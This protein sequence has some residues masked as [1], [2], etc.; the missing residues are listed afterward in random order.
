MHGPFGTV[1]IKV[2]YEYD[3]EPYFGSQE[4]Y[5][6]DKDSKLNAE[7]DGARPERDADEPQYSISNKQRELT[8]YDEMERVHTQRLLADS[9]E[10]L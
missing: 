8:Y 4:V 9:A 5:S 10:E 1:G 2:D 3:L 7:R 6:E